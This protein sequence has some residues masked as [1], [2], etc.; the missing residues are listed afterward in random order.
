MKKSFP[1]MLSIIAV[2][3]LITTGCSKIDE[4]NDGCPSCDGVVRLTPPPYKNEAV[5]VNIIKENDYAIRQLRMM[6]NGSYMIACETA[7]IRTRKDYSGPETVSFSYEFGE[8]SYDH[9]VF[10]FDNGMTVSFESTGGT[11]YDITITW[12][13]GTVI[14]TTGVIDPTLKV[15]EGV[16]TDNLCSRAWTIQNIRA[17]G[18]FNGVRVAK[19][20]FPPIDLA[21]IKDWYLDNGGRLEDD[22]QTNTVLLGIYFDEYGMFA[23]NYENRKADIG[24]WRWLNMDEGKLAIS[25]NDD[26]TAISLFAASTSVAFFKDPE[27]CQL[28]L[29]GNISGTD[30]EFVFTL[31]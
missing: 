11:G 2:M 12:K 7:D 31:Q 3:L 4:V 17:I 6:G 1:L 10:V 16:M 21:K 28:T 14:N 27:T 25:W 19:D 22:F 5:V 24:Q 8:Y 20:F 9:G 29:K 26:I 30:M 23:I 13:N 18:T 15:D